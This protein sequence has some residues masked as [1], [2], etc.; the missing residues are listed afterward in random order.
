MILGLGMRGVEW[1]KSGEKAVN[2]VGVLSFSSFPFDRPFP[3]PIPLDLTKEE[4]MQNNTKK[5]KNETTEKKRSCAA[6]TSSASPADAS[7]I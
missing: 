2:E 1:R 5:Q 6:A 3:S 7:F 4:G